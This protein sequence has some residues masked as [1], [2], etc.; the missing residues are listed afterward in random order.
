MAWFPVP[1]GPGREEEGEAAVAG[2]EALERAP[3]AAEQVKAPVVMAWEVLAPAKPV[4]FHGWI[5]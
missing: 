4:E 2:A 3:A 1:G 5:P